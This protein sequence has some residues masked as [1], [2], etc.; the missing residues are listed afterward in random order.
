MRQRRRG[1]CVERVSRRRAPCAHPF[2]LLLDDGIPHGGP[3]GGR[4]VNL[5]Y[6][7]SG[8]AAGARC[9]AG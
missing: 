9:T 4:S 3:W 2:P 8:R 5:H 1:P 6:G 7:H